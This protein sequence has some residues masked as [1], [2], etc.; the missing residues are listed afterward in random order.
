MLV[1][2]E[3]ILARYSALVE[4]QM[5]AV[6][7]SRVG[8]SAFYD[9]MRYHLGWRDEQLAPLATRSGKR[10][11][12]ALTVLSCAVHGG[13][14]E[15][16]APAAAAVELLHNF[17]LIHDDIEDGDERRRGR[18]TV[19]KLFGI[20]HAL[21][22]GDGLHTLANLALFAS[23]SR[24]DDSTLLTL[25][26]TLDEACL[27]IC[28]GQYLDLA[29]ESRPCV[30]PE[31]YLDMIGRKTAALLRCSTLCGAAL[32]TADE[33]ARQALAAFGFSLGMAFQV[34]DDVL[35]IWGEPSVTGKP[36][37]DDLRRHK[38]TFPVVAA[39][40]RLTPAQAA[41]VQSLYARPELDD[42]AVAEVAGLLAAC[43]AR[44]AAER[45]A[46]RYYQ[47]ALA[48]VEGRLDPALPAVQDL[49]ELARFLAARS[50]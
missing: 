8:P 31:E 15:Q 10:A 45:L 14:A 5:R 11:R 34:R 23:R 4:D 41:H 37:G 17:T 44:D 28:E 20:P 18:P 39:Q 12:A 13:P 42:A 40:S 35:G 32:G 38:K 33:G 16:A 1:S 47:Q 36:A 21:N 27:T 30:S 24:L 29:F 6:L 50:Y 3:E 7:D 48:H 2:A 43:G 22:A 19:W 46:D 49:L 9:L 25:C 26:Q